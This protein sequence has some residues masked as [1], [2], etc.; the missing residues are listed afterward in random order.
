[1]TVIKTRYVLTVT[2]PDGYGLVLEC[3]APAQAH[4]DVIW[5]LTSEEFRVSHGN[6]QA[7]A[8][9]LVTGPPPARLTHEPTGLVFR[10]ESTTVATKES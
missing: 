4:R 8:E 3:A 7:F 1:M 10:Y 9:R 2:R 5:L 6:A